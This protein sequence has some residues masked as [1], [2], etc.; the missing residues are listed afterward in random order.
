MLVRHHMAPGQL[1]AQ[2]STPKAYKKLAL[3][4]APDCTLYFL[5][6]LA[7]ADKSSRPEKLHE[8]DEFVQRAQQ[9]GV[10]YVPEKPLVTGNDLMPLGLSGA[11]LGNAL[12]AA[13]AWQIEQSAPTRETVLRYV[14]GMVK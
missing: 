9:Y 1:V 10:L 4:L 3:V 13:Y 11:A 8:V 6:Q 14:Q 12:R 5:A 7:Y 2:N